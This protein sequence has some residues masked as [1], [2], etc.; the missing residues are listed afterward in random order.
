MRSC[1]HAVAATSLLILPLTAHAV[2]PDLRVYA[3]EYPVPAPPRPADVVVVG[4]DVGPAPMSTLGAAN[5]A[6]LEALTAWDFGA[7][8]GQRVIV[9]TVPV[10]DPWSCYVPDP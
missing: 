2:D 4:Y 1:R 6:A 10:E 8:S 3:D 9:Q 5:A 7:L